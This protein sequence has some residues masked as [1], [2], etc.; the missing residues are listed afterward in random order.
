MAAGIARNTLN[1]KQYASNG[2]RIELSVRGV[3]GNETTT[4]GTTGNNNDDFR[5]NHAWVE[6]RLKYQ[7][8]FLKL[9]PVAFGFD[10]EA[11]Y[12]NKPFFQNY[13]ASIISAPA[14][15]PI[16]ESKT[17]FINE[18]RTTEYA[19]LGL[20]SVFSIRRNIDFRLEGYA[21][22]PFKS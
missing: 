2:S 16:P 14:Y 10:L 18:F 7:N 13:Y 8:Y 12:S 6:T 20:M 9:G 21:F 19:G 15:Q 5:E 4:F 11:L 22:Q 17:I 1:R 3:F